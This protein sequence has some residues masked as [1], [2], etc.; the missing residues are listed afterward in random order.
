[1]T[2]SNVQATTELSERHS[3]TAERERSAAELSKT[4]VSGTA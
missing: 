1:M 4:Y 2:C 3:A